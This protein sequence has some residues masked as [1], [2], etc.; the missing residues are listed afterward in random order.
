MKISGN[1][2]SYIQELFEFNK[3]KTLI[4]DVKKKKKISYNNFFKNMFVWTRILKEKVIIDKPKIA[5]IA[6]HSSSVLLLYFSV[7]YLGGT[8]ISI[9]SNRGNKEISELLTI[10]KPDMILYSEEAPKDFLNKYTCKKISDFQ[11]DEEVNLKNKDSLWNNAS[12]D[13]AKL[14]SFSSGT[15]GIPKGIINSLGNLLLS[16][17]AFRNKFKFNGQNIFYHNLPMAY[18]AG[19]LNLWLLPMI[20]GSSIVIEKRFNI[21]SVLNFWD[22][23]LKYN[24]N[25]FWLIPTIIELLLKLDR[26]K[27]RANFI[28]LNK[29]IIACV[30]TAPLNNISKNNFEEKYGILLYESYGL[31]ET[32]FVATNY[33]DLAEKSY[34]VGQLLDEVQL[35]FNDENEIL[36]KVPW[37]FKGYIQSENNFEEYFSSGDIGQLKENYLYITG[38]KKDL[39]IKGGVNISPRRLEDFF[40]KNEFFEEAS[41]IGI[42]DDILGEKIVC[43]F[44]EKRI[45]R[46]TDI[47][48][49]NQSILKDLGKDYYVDVFFKV[50]KIP[51]NINGKVDKMK[52]KEIYNEEC[53]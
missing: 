21:N 37:A 39:I 5:I 2:N 12:F 45:H 49:I 31:S 53:S 42:K 16:A 47:K 9:D 3:E 51:K 34:S 26:D 28:K 6:D 10:S 13:S 23:P 14:I 32:L 4:I 48:E 41:I 20:S 8:V 29:K 43:C 1:V 24:V 38:R 25:V 35:D 30:G 40:I 11:Y 18:M 50:D 33:P 7:F 36:I 52:L 44:V 17:I 15:T 22:T 19:I 46:Y 27:E